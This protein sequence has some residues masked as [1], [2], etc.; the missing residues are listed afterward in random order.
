MSHFI[1]IMPPKVQTASHTGIKIREPQSLFAKMCSSVPLTGGNRWRRVLGMTVF[2]MRIAVFYS[3]TVREADHFP[4][5]IAPSGS[6]RSIAITHLTSD[7]TLL[8]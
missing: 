4:P 1:A 7:W 3:R 2:G 5:G 8:T 6:W